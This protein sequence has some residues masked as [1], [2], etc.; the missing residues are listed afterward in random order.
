MPF[1]LLEKGEIIFVDVRKVDFFFLFIEAFLF[2][3]LVD[4]A[5]VRS[6]NKTAMANWKVQVLC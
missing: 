4:V 5:W 3:R 6:N 2:S 1:G